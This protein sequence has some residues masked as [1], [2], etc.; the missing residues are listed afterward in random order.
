MTTKDMTTKEYLSQAFDL[1]RLVRAKESRIQ[2]LRD[3]QTRIAQATAGVK[4][5]SSPGPDSMGELAA[6]LLDLIADYER[7]CLRLLQLQDDIEDT[8][9]QVE[10]P[11][12]YLVLF[13]RY[14]N[15]KKWEDIAADAGYGLRH[16]HKLHGQALVYLDEMLFAHD[17]YTV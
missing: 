3:K 8:I 13:Q 2:D 4:V 9:S 17:T 14:V 5:Q 15:L 10:S 6:I 1:A 11:A 7:D 12:H 16:T